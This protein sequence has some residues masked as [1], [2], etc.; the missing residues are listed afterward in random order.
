MRLSAAVYATAARP[1][2]RAPPRWTR[3][4]CASSQSLG[5]NMKLHPF[6][7]LIAC[8]FGVVFVVLFGAAPTGAAKVPQS[9][10]T[11]V[12]W[13]SYGNDL[14]NT[15]FQ[16]LDQIN[17]TN[18]AQLQPAWIFHTGVNDKK[19]SLEVS[20]IEISGTLYVTDG[21]DDAFALDAASAT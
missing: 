21:H 17:P 5:G 3:S 20:P 1:L 18:V 6:R 4:D 10:A 8:T 16:N 14:A 2:P 11:T 9:T 15:R 13:P 7:V 19:S 12:D